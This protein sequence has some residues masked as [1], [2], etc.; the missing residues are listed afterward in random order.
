MA[1]SDLDRAVVDMGSLVDSRM[2]YPSNS[3]L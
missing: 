1:E 2:Q 3:V